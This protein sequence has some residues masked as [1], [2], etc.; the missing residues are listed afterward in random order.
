MSGFEVAG[1]MLGAIPLVISALEHYKSGKSTASAI[2]QWRGQLDTLIFRLKLLDTFFYLESLELLRAAKVPEVIDGYDLTKDECAAILLS[3]KTGKEMQE[4]LGPLHG[5]AL[6]I[7]GRYETCLKKIV[8]KIHHI[9]RLDGAAKDDLRALLDTNPPAAGCF[10]FKKRL[11]F[12]LERDSLKTL[13]EDLREDR[14]SL[15]EITNTLKSQKGFTARS[16]S[17]NVAKMVR[18]L[19][20]VQ[21]KAVSLFP[22]LCGGCTCRC[23][24]KH[25]VMTRLERRLEGRL[26]AS[27]AKDIA[28]RLV[29]PLNGPDAILQQAWKTLPEEPALQLTTVR[30]ILPETHLQAQQ[31]VKDLSK[32]EMTTAVDD[33]S[34]ATTLQELL[35]R[36]PEQVN[37]WLTPKRRILLLAVDIA[38]SIL[39]IQRS[40]W[41]RSPWSS[42][43]IKI[44]VTQMSQP[45]LS[46]FIE[47]DLD[48]L[49]GKVSIAANNL[50]PQ[51]AILELSILLLEVWHRKSVEAWASKANID[52]STLGT[53]SRR[54][55]AE[56]WL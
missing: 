54:L 15:K 44:A 4:F 35:A 53:D 9:R 31:E 51:T 26:K 39:Q 32:A 18:Q 22:A 36:D 16:S 52:L 41:L 55:A 17:H 19:A 49:K 12:S 45:I 14:L 13:L 40:H 43:T 56:R 25:R 27:L 3:A 23:Q 6:E 30:F 1:I 42:Q 37:D 2:F 33:I 8:V 5:I 48:G 24:A 7:I 38:S 21:S 34:V 47:Q 11:K 10:A 20:Q 28:F 50:E 46:A 29:L